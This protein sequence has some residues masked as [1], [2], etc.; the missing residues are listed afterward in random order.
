MPS[1]LSSHK[2]LKYLVFGKHAYLSG[3]MERK[4]WRTPLFLFEVSTS[5]SCTPKATTTLRGPGLLRGSRRKRSEVEA[6]P[7]CYPID[8]DHPVYSSFWIPR[9]AP[10]QQDDP[11]HRPPSLYHLVH[12]TELKSSKKTETSSPRSTQKR[13][14]VTA[15]LW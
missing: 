15:R 3:R 13:R 1:V 9:V 6:E 14:F 10:G 2:P 5:M 4:A 7:R 8:V 11:T 12:G